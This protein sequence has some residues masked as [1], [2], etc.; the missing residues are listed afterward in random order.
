MAKPSKSKKSSDVSMH[1]HSNSSEKDATVRK[2]AKIRRRQ[3]TKTPGPRGGRKHRET[4]TAKQISRKRRML[5][6]GCTLSEHSM[7]A[8]E[9]VSNLDLLAEILLC[10]PAKSLV[11]FKSVSKH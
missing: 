5:A 2:P 9:V 10:M 4:K 6:I 3:R 1:R 8:E 11:R 7:E